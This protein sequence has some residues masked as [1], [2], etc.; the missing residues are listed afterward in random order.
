M[1]I[2]NKSKT[3]KPNM[4]QKMR[5]NPGLKWWAVPPKK[6]PLSQGLKVK[7]KQVKKV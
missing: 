6:G 1:S 2:K 7:P 5:A 3:K 4:A